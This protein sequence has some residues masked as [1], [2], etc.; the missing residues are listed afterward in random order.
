MFNQ[1]QGVFLV[2]DP[3]L[4]LLAAIAHCSKNDLGDL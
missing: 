3:V 2:E 4:P 1:G